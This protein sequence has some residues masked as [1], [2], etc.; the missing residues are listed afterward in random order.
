MT[1]SEDLLEASI[2]ELAWK[3]LSRLESLLSKV[4]RHAETHRH[5]LVGWRSMCPWRAS[6]VFPIHCLR[7]DDRR[8]NKS[9]ATTCDFHPSKTTQISGR[10]TIR[11]Y[12]LILMQYFTHSSKPKFLRRFEVLCNS[13]LVELALWTLAMT[14]VSICYHVT[15][16]LTMVY[17]RKT[18]GHCSNRAIWAITHG[19]FRISC[20]IKMTTCFCFNCCN[21]PETYR[22]LAT[23]GTLFQWDETSVACLRLYQIST[24]VH[25]KLF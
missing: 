25:L 24:R 2:G 9:W 17:V 8:T 3:L 5:A 12:F 7:E 19:L 16:A 18:L 20:V 22:L 23:R 6:C 4:V 1:N 11:K 10:M 21:A 13:S 14:L 15:I